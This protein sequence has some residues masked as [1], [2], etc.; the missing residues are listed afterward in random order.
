MDFNEIVLRA[1]QLQPFMMHWLRGLKKVPEAGLDLPRT[2]SFI[3][4]TLQELGVPLKTGYAGGSGIVARLKGDIKGKGPVIVIRADMD[5]LPIN[6]G[7]NIYIAHVCGHDAHMAMALG[8]LALLKKIDCW[9]GEVRVLFQPGEEG[10]GG[11][12]LMVKEGALINAECA[13]A[14]HL[15]PKYPLGVV[16]LRG[17][18]LNAYLDI[19]EITVTGQGGHGAYPHQTV[20][21]VVAAASFI[22][23]LQHLVSRNVPPG[24]AAVIT[25]GKV[26]GGEAPNVISEQVIMEGS[27]R[28]LKESTRKIIHHRLKEI[29]KGT[30]IQYGANLRTDIKNGYPPVINDYNLTELCY[31]ELKKALDTNLVEIKEPIMGSDDFAFIAQQIPSLLFR[32]GCAFPDRDNPPLHNPNFSF[33]TDVLVTG[34]S[35][36]SYLVLSLLNQSQATAK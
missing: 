6:D 4:V 13:L 5:A 23:N 9:I 24:E 32:L 18:Q 36:L 27:L 8:T 25:V 26:L 2:S 3:K 20:D 21:A 19:F 35:C 31:N 16:A 22:L 28:C 10:P 14:L 17:G 30:A 15:D 11:A 33:P 34:C 7:K 29:G 12:H 1:Q